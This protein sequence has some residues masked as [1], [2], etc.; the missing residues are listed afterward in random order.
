MK[1]NVP[2]HCPSISDGHG[3]LHW[4]LSHMVRQES[5]LKAMAVR[6]VEIM[7]DNR[8]PTKNTNVPTLLCS[9]PL[10]SR[11]HSKQASLY[12]HSLASRGG[13]S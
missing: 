3:R 7:Y 1:E 4:E 5:K 10:P 13:E 9:R 6:K 12:A 11:E 2:V 8:K